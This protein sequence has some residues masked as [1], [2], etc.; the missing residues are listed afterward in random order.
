MNGGTASSDVFHWGSIEWSVFCSDDF[1]VGGVASRQGKIW[2]ALRQDR[3]RHGRPGVGAWSQRHLPQDR[4]ALGHARTHLV[5]S[6]CGKP[7]NMFRVNVRNK[8]SKRLCGQCS[9]LI[10]LIRL[11][12]NSIRD[13]V[14]ILPKVRC[15][16]IRTWK[17]TSCDHELWSCCAK[18]EDVRSCAYS[19]KHLFSSS[20]FI[21][22]CFQT[23]VR[24]ICFLWYKSTK[25]KE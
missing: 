23:N 22:S 24:V 21:A 12:S 11:S 3:R 8:F 10:S 19:V 7:Y 18:D 15:H 4:A 16:W 13:A 20:D 6:D 5:G 1:A 2:R 9:N 17:M 25:L 14:F